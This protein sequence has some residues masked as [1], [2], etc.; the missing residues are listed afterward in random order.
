MMNRESIRWIG[1]AGLALAAATFVAG[2]AAAQGH[3]PLVPVIGQ[4]VTYRGLD[5]RGTGCQVYAPYDQHAKIAGRVILPDT[6]ANVYYFVE[7]W[8]RDTETMV[9]RLTPGGDIVQYRLGVEGRTLIR[10]PVGTY[11]EVADPFEGNTYRYEV[12]AD[13]LTRT[14]PAGTFSNVLRL[15]VFCMTC[16]PSPVLQERFYLSPDVLF[17][18]VSITWD[19]QHSCWSRWHSLVSVTGK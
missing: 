4:T 9:F 18:I 14:V 15:D 6:A 7:A 8:G 5:D 13:G 3:S 1:L 16:G 11:S 2:R 12:A 10:G 17:P 19:A